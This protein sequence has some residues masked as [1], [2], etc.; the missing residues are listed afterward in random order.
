[1]HLR[2]VTSGAEQGKGYPLGH[3]G[4]QRLSNSAPISLSTASQIEQGTQ[5]HSGCEG[6]PG[7]VLGQLWTHHTGPEWVAEGPCVLLLAWSQG[8][9]CLGKVFLINA[10]LS[11][12]SPLA[13]SERAQSSYYF[14]V[15]PHLC[16]LP[17]YPSF[18][19]ALCLLLT[20]VRGLRAFEVSISSWTLLGRTRFG[21]WKK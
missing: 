9:P 14:H 1:M 7:L 8:P 19:L 21:G 11:H 18:P 12:F 10:L 2:A 15:W 20:F 4:S 13:A 6:L 17:P 5:S 3:L 16:H